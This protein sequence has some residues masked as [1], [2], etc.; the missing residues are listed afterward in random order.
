V[1]NLG[2]KKS[3]G[4]DL[5]INHTFFTHYS[6]NFT[7][8]SLISRSLISMQL[9]I[10]TPGT[11]L[12]RDNALFEIRHKDE[13]YRIV[14][15]KIDQ[16]LL[17]RGIHVTTDALMMA[18]DHGIDII[19]TDLGGLPKGR[20][21]NNKFGSI[22]TIRRN[23]ILFSQTS[24]GMDW[25]RAKLAQKISFQIAFLYQIRYCQAEKEQITKIER[26]LKQMEQVLNQVKTKKNTT[27]SLDSTMRGW[28]GTVSKHYFQS[29]SLALPTLY[30][31]DTRN[32]RPAKDIFNC[33]LNYLYGMLYAQVEGALIKAGIDPSI[34]IWHTDE[35]NKPVLSY[36]FIE[37]YRVWADVI[38][39]RL[40]QGYA[41]N[42][43][44]TI[45]HEGGIW[46]AGIGKKLVIQTF[47]DYLEE[48]IPYQNR[49]RSRRTHIQLDA[50]EF[51][52]ML[53]KYKS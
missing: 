33:V 38:A 15:E 21:W 23:Q 4:S 10:D 8:S 27:S 11:S 51:A 43:K 37:P 46:L 52:Q 1:V 6:L 13:K 40:C 14:P 30:R 12:N 50:H 26:A 22:T 5:F 17:S 53:L 28:E 45:P 24:E 25:I 44:E 2:V 32:R 31:F 9:I 34:G 41:I 48:V 20:I 16:I 47:N 18:L 49:Q 19:F 3:E 35:Y 29:I 7:Y 39:F 42:S 36:D